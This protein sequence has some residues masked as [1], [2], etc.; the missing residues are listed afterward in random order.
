[1]LQGVRLVHGSPQFSGQDDRA[2]QGARVLGVAL[3]LAFIVLNLLTSIWARRLI[4]FKK[5]ETIR[6]AQ[7]PNLVMVGD[8]MTEEI[9]PES[10]AKGA[11]RAD[12]RPLNAAL[13][14]TE[15]PEHQLLFEYAARTYPAIHT[16]VIG[17]F[18][19][20]LTAPVS[21]SVRDLV[22]NRMLGFDSRFPRP[23]VAAVYGLTWQ[24]MAEI[25][26]I[27]AVPLVANRGNFVKY[28]DILHDSQSFV[29]MRRYL[30]EF[31][32]LPAGVP[33]AT[34]PQDFAV[35]EAATPEIFDSEA[36][37]FTDHPDHFSRNY[38]AIFS[39]AHRAGMNVIIVLM[40]VSPLHR[41]VFYDRPRWTNY[42]NALTDLAKRRGIR[43]V[44]A[45]GWISSPEDFQDHVHMTPEAARRFAFRLGDELA[46]TQ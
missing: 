39:Q 10:L 35:S 14:G 12:L 40:P 3:L 24:E 37:F 31:G 11:A 16:V 29:S 27:R 25:D 34:K 46:K 19:F 33:V 23:E 17:I 6:L 7:N 38:E 44:N 1:L 18:D 22:G 2:V 26:A 5:L 41:S 42:V 43:I 20:Q 36:R 32:L 45:I 15:A 30:N 9:L 28:I 13:G 8:S 21:R 4:Y